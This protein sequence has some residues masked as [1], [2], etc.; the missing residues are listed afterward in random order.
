M[1]P[2]LVECGRHLN[3]RLMTLSQ[4]TKIT[5]TEG[6]FT[7]TVRSYPRYVD[8]DKCISCGECAT[9][10]PVN[11][12]DKYK[13]GVSETKAIS[14]QYPQAVPSS[15]Q[16]D[17][18]SCIKI[19]D[20]EKCGVCAKIC[21]A[22]AICFEDTEKTTT[23][24]TGAIILSPGFR[25][26]D[27]SK[28]GMW[29][30]GKF[31]NVITSIQLEQ[32]L[33]TTGPTGGKLLRPTDNK[34]VRKMAFL[35]CVGSR[36]KNRCQNEYCSSVCC[37]YA[38]KEA[39]VAK[40]RSP[41]LDVSIF[42]TDIRTHGKDFDRYYNRA[43]NEGGIRFIRS[44]AHDVEPSY[45]DSALRLHYINDNGLQCEESFDLIVLSV[46]METTENTAQLADMM[47]I[48]L[49]A[50]RFAS[51]S[52]FMP[53]L[54]S[55]SGI[56]TCGALAGP[57]DIS[58]SVTEGS[59]AAAGI[60]ALLSS[61]RHTLTRQLHFPP[62]RDTSQEDVRIGVFICH[63]GLNIAGVI[64]VD[65]VAHFSA[66]LPFV[67][68][69]EQNL[70][71]C[72]PD[73]QKI[74][75]N[76]IEEKGL[77]RIV[78][79]ACTPR[80]YESFFHQ[81]LRQAGMNEHLLEMANIRNQNSWVHG[82]EP[83]QATT[84]ARDL[85]RMAVAKTAL[86][87]PSQ[88]S[89]IS[90]NQTALIVGGGLAG[91]TSALNLA[92]QGFK[93][94]LVEKT[95]ELGGNANYL[96]QTWNGEDIPIFI[97]RLKH[98]VS[99]H[100]N[101]RLLFDTEVISSEGHAG[102]FRTTLQTGTK[103]EQLK[104]GA[105]II[106]SGGKR[107][108]PKE[109]GYGKFPGVFTSLE[110]D[111]LHQYGDVRVKKG[112]C[113]VFIQCVGSRDDERPYCSKVCCTHSVQSAIRLKKEDHNRKIYILYR[114]IRTYSQRE[115]LYTIARQLGIVF[116]N[117]DLHGKPNISLDEKWMQVEVWDHVLHRPLIIQADVIILAVAILPNNE[118]TDLA[119]IFKIPLNED[120]FFLEAHSKL[121]PVDFTTEGVFMAGLAH[122]PKPI[123]ES[124]GQALATASRAATLLSKKE[125][126]VDGI[127][128]IV[129]TEQC[130]GCAL[131]IDVC[132]YNA[133]TLIETT[134]SQGVEHKSVVINEVVCTGCGL[135]QGTC[136]IRGVAVT[137]FS[138]EQISA[139]LTAALE[140]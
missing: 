105:T 119:Q 116:I 37:M 51:T 103:K 112:N 23:I 19:N 95:H 1:A 128:A 138:F 75:I 61:Q 123:E 135:C 35:Q 96:H 38:I 29:G 125:M 104:H 31:L 132:P 113:F 7:V 137:G 115:T 76:R 111:K 33:S 59:A 100:E 30:Y 3:I 41:E 18:D 58:M 81:T 56:Y 12:L 72:S 47:G 118:A 130:D 122:H 87:K 8:I 124:I 74:I 49:S 25:P 70:F 54:T 9:N 117:Y 57:K 68:H 89:T 126:R 121:R 6:D 97:T 110:F 88:S 39:L 64:D 45:D 46:G 66:T 139:E 82:N 60:A 106:A 44:R 133:I 134:D 107:F 4:V 21:P 90:I 94:C 28:T 34:P 85:V 22:D 83:Q 15:Y 36:D 53:V 101:I 43:E 50:D 136:P 65:D 86:Q 5:G 129:N 102:N 131:C 55:R 73:T 109:Y 80:N 48:H 99:Q 78:I 91:M 27:P 32:Y 69:V 98:H 120:G 127:Q 42:F 10:C 2:K 92:K 40:E 108:I 84:K 67:V 11:I 71:A 79:A 52:S 17:K 93:V 24:E 26:F 63:C 13:S 16:I 77:N 114:D 14:I 140:D 62:E 20:P